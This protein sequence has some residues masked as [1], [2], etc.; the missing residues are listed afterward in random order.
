M[1]MNDNDS[2]DKVTEYLR[3]NLK[4]IEDRFDAV[5]DEN[6]LDTNDD[7]KMLLYSTVLAV[8]NMAKLI[9]LLR[10]NASDPPQASHTP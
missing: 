6:E 5:F 2:L 7:E 4:I 3:N 10:G 8:Q 9:I 1:A